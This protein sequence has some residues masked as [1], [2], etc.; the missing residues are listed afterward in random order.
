LGERDREKQKVKTMRVRIDL[1][2]IVAHD[3]LEITD[4]LDECRFFINLMKRNSNWNEFRWLTSAFLNGAR[5]ALDWLAF[6]VYHT[7]I[8]DEGEFYPDTEALKK[9]SKYISIN[10]VPKTGKV[11][12]SPVDPLLKE[13]CEHRK[14]TA[15]Q[16]S[17][18]IK[19]EKVDSPD[20]FRFS[21]GGHHVIAFGEKV[22]IL[23]EHI[24][25]EVR[26]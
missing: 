18:R 4:K 12:V 7:W 13:L 8:D 16:D 25:I 14:I 5:S 26:Q 19:P 6:A 23:L 3:P 21:K 17:I 9:L 20:D 24:H 15:H 22:L 11:F 1:S 10:H 2:G